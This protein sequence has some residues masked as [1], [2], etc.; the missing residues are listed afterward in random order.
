M[1]LKFS[2]PIGE[3]QFPNAKQVPSSYEN[4]VF[5]LQN[6]DYNASLNAGE[7]LKMEFTGL[8]AKYNEAAPSATLELHPGNDAE[9]DMTPLPT[10]Y[11][12]GS[13]P[14]VQ[15]TS[16][17]VLIEE[18]PNGFKMNIGIL[19]QQKVEG[20]WEMIIKFPISVE[21]LQTPNALQK[22]TSED[23]KEYILENEQYNAFLPKCSRLEMIIIRRKAD[24][25]EP[26]GEV[27]IEFRRKENWMEEDEGECFEMRHPVHETS[28]TV[29]P[30]WHKCG[31]SFASVFIFALAISLLPRN[32]LF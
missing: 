29:G 13:T 26:P 12:P 32:I 8:E 28:N 4:K 21:A 31:I 24:K 3:Q 16:K 7:I 20:R 6:W 1:T 19:L 9:C 30:K 14:P 25:S 22:S 10:I 2:K 27:D 17:A 23:R 15:E 18:W 5:C 11:P